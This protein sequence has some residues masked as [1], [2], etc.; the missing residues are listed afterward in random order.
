[1]SGSASSADDPLAPRVLRDLSEHERTRSAAPGAG[2]SLPAEAPKLSRFEIQE[3]IGQGATA[4]VYRARDKTLN[5]SVAVKVLREGA[6]TN[7]APL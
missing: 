4:V 3:S 7:P 2:S 6:G 5:R 1:M